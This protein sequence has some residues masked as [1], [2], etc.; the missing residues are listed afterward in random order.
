MTCRNGIF[1]EDTYCDQVTIISEDPNYRYVIMKLLA[2]LPPSVY[3][4][5]HFTI[6]S[7]ATRYLNQSAEAAYVP[8][9][10]PRTILMNGAINL[11]NFTFYHEF[12][13]LWAASRAGIG[14]QIL[15]YTPFALFFSA[16]FAP[17]EYKDAVGY[18]RGLNGKHYLYPP[19][20]GG[21]GE[22][23]TPDTYDNIPI[24]EEFA[25]SFGDFFFLKCQLKE[26]SPER[27]NYFIEYVTYGVETC[28]K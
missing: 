2:Q 19:V 22:Y 7:F 3:E 23:D 8:G 11:N 24:Q 5:M 12:G 28:T 9:S 4:G 15:E 26:L 13:H 18:G 14:Q 27:Y 1:Q 16:N 21:Y 17:Q 20:T 6:R 10:I 25:N